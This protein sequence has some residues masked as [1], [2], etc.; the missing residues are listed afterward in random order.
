MINIFNFSMLPFETCLVLRSEAGKVGLLL[1]GFA[2]N[3]YPERYA[4]KNYRVNHLN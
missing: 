4:D 1:P 2:I 3:R